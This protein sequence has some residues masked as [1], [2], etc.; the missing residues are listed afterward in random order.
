M[1]DV[2]LMD[3]P[4]IRTNNPA[5]IAEDVAEQIDDPAVAWALIN[6]L[7]RRHDLS[8]AIID[9]AAVCA[10]I[11]RSVTDE[12]FAAMQR[13]KSWQTGS[14]A[15]GLAAVAATASTDLR[16]PSSDL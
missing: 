9:R 8:V 15:G 4:E 16:W 2:M 12:E 14:W 6:R 5:E 11:G 3:T 1:M 7:A 10:A 13:S